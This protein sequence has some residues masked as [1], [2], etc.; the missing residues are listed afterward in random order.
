MCK[1]NKLTPRKF[2]SSVDHSRGAVLDHEEAANNSYNGNG[3]LA[4]QQLSPRN[5]AC[6]TTSLFT[7]IW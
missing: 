7:L 6:R 1:H 4:A 2:G 5:L 3:R